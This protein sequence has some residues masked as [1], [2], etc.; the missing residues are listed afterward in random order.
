MQSKKL[1]DS[2]LVFIGWRNNAGIATEIVHSGRGMNGRRDLF[3]LNDTEALIILVS[4]PRDCVDGGRR[5]V[6][7]RSRLS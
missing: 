4:I 1:Q 5:D 2:A 3:A 7:R 6:W